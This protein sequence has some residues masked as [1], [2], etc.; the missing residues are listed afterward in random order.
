MQGRENRRWRATVLKH[1]TN[2][3][4]QAEKV[5]TQNPTLAQRYVQMARHIVLRTRVRLPPTLQHRY[6]HRC[7]KFL[8]PGINARVRLRS[9]GRNGTMV[10]TCLSCGYRRKLVWKRNKNHAPKM[11][12][13]NNTS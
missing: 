6:C 9:A 1:L 8:Q 13:Q 11:D 3:F 4:Q 7:E 10:I 2:L 12:I 5:A